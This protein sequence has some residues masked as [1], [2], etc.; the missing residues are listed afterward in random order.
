MLDS[1]LQGRLVCSSQSFLFWIFILWSSLYLTFSDPFGLQFLDVYHYMIHIILWVFIFFA[2]TRIFNYITN[3][4]YCPNYE[5]WD[6]NMPMW[7]WTPTV[8]LYPFWMTPFVIY[9]LYSAF[10]DPEYFFNA[11]FDRVAGIISISLAANMIRDSIESSTLLF[12]TPLFVAHHIAS[13]LGHMMIFFTPFKGY[14]LMVSSTLFLEYGSMTYGMVIIWRHKWLR[15][16]DFFIMT[17]AHAIV[18]VAAIYEFN[19]SMEN[20]PKV[21]CYGVLVMLILSYMRQQSAWARLL[22]K[23]HPPLK[24]MKAN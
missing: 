14:M 12:N 19:D 16:I 10:T 7:C 3:V 20:H 8:C 1:T 9:M 21:Y 11:R 17:C 24:R 22:E 5:N 15:Y 23:E 13:F 4:S 18:P 6:D 2:W